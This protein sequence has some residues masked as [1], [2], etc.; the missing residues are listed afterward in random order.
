MVASLRHFIHWKHPAV[1]VSEVLEW[2]APTIYE[3][4]CRYEATRPAWRP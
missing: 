4:R 2:E 1:M 3:V